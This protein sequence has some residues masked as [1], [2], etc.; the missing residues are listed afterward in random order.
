MQISYASD[1]GSVDKPNEDWFYASP[2][3]IVVL[4]GS[5]ARTETGC[6]HGVAWYSQHLGEAIVRIAGKDALVDVLAEAI[7]DV[8]ALHPECDL[9]SPGTPSAAAAIVRLDSDLDYLVLSDV[10]LVVDT[11]KG[12]EI[13][14]D[15]RVSSTGRPARSEAQSWPLDAPERAPLVLQMKAGELAA[16][17]TSG[18]YWI[19]A[20]DPQAAEHAL[21]GSVELGDVRRIAAVS[22]G[23]ASA[24]DRYGLLT[25]AA[26]LDL[27]A[28]PGPG[29]LIEQVRSAEAQDLNAVRWPRMKRADDATVVFMDLQEDDPE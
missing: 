3:L 23:A 6:R 16:R 11:A 20:A 13:V 12:I 4:D 15:P 1:P 9:T 22:D 21:T 5:T 2:E 7:S 10:T 28:G 18:G 17:N 27:L 8:V 29:R 25:W 14:T 19:A 26:T 24:V